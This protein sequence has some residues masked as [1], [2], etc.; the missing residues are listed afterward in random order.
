MPVRVPVR[1][2]VRVASNFS[3][4]TSRPASA[5]Q[6]GSPRCAGRKRCAAVIAAR[7]FEMAGWTW[8]DVDRRNRKVFG[9]PEPAVLPGMPPEDTPEALIE[10]ECCKL[11]SEDQWRILK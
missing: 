9:E 4:A 6:M 3:R 11:L 2:A 1:R 8:E 10:A 7:S 5:G